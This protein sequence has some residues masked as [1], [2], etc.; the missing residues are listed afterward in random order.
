ML[1]DL[2]ELNDSAVFSQCEFP[3]FNLLN[4]NLYPNKIPGFVK[5]AFSKKHSTTNF[6]LLRNFG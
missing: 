2:V 4:G 6:L 3:Q 5:N 1:E